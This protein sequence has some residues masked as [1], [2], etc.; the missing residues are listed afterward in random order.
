[1]KK[2]ITAIGFA[3]S[4]IALTQ[5]VYLTAVHAAERKPA[6]ARLPTEPGTPALIPAGPNAEVIAKLAHYKNTP[7]NDAATNPTEAAAGANPPLIDGNFLVGPT[8]VAA[9]ELSVTAG[10]PEGKIQQFSM[11]S[12]NSKFYPGIARNA[13]GTVD[14]NNPKTLIVETHPAP[15][16]RTVTVYIP[17]QYVAGKAAPFI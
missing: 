6:P 5:A 9:P 15:Y 12:T 2:P 11:E 4:L 7:T 13:F 1:M 10:V 16:K 3:L 17:S 8:Y 14:P